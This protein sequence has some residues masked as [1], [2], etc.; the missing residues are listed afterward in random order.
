MQPFIADAYLPLSHKSA[1]GDLTTP[2][3]GAPSWVDPVNARRLAAYQ[4]LHA[5]AANAARHYLPDNFT[6]DMRAK[7]REYGDAGLLILQARAA[8]LGDDQTV[9]IPDADVELPDNPNEQQQKSS[10][11]LQQFADWLDGWA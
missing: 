3:Q 8:L 1:L 5:Y 11:R 2:A 10:A 9:S 7:Y 4:V 6:D